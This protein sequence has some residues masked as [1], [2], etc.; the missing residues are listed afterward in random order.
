VSESVR[1]LLVEDSETDAKLIIHELDRALGRLHTQRVDT[2]AGLQQ[3]LE[4]ER[5]D[6]ILCDWSLPGLDALAAIELL[7]DKELDIP[8]I[9]VSGTVGEEA[10][11]RAMR[12]G[13]RDYVLKDKLARLPVAVEREIRET[14]ARLERRRSQEALRISE[15][16]FARLSESGI[17]GIAIADLIGGILEANDAYL[18]ICGFTREELLEGKMN[19]ARMTP[20]EFKPL[21][22]KAVELL[23]TTGAAAPWEMEHIRN[24]GTRIPVM[25]AVAMLDEARCLAIIT[26]LSERRRAEE[27]LRRTEEQ[28]RH[29]QKM[30]AIGILA[31]G[32]AH[33]FNNLLSVILGY[34]G[35]I[36][37]DLAP[38]HPLRAD[39]EEIKS[40]GER[41]ASLT[42]R[43][44]AF[45]RQQ[46]VEPRI[47]DVNEVINNIDA[48]LRRLIRE[49]VTLVT[50]LGAPLGSCRADPGQ[51]EQ[52]LMNLAVNAVDAMPGGG[53]LTLE[54]ANVDLDEEYVVAHIGMKPGRY[55]LLAVSDTG[56]G[57]TKATQAR[58]FEPFFTTKEKGKGTGLGLA[59]VFGI[60]Q[61]AGG[62]IQLY[63]EL[64]HG[65]TFKIYLPRVD[66]VPER[67]TASVAPPRARGAETILLVEDEDQL[68]RVAAGILRR[69]GFQVLEGS[70]GPEALGIIDKNPEPIDLL[71]TDV[72]M[73]HMNGRE[74]AERVRA[75]RPD[76]KILFTSG[77]TDGILEGE[78]PSG[79][80]F[81][82]KPFTPG[83]L[84]T[85]IR[86]ILDAAADPSR[87]LSKKGLPDR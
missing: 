25:V 45:S 27:Q 44:L 41:G 56:V 3:A 9:I 28:L 83:A 58:V 35:M 29:V 73:P 53:R 6:V 78:L 75:D 68:R 50:R 86:E 22:D 57:M 5:W 20:L 69:S 46:V 80:A 62:S 72:V 51:I 49:D 8:L 31:G 63:S 26:D 42:R 33:D 39:V 43:L 48:M 4:R 74:L 18:R 79:A 77:Y 84:T 19:W 37:E 66:L 52:I 1:V 24:D 36:L 23:R 67:G 76:I 71:M 38:D 30:E 21:T 7:K 13:A 65:T 85:K 64:G 12:A 70:N 59:T 60:V 81:L 16:R 2:A 14:R 61:Q 10:A 55:V 40:A 32:V 54:T 11:V 34:C 87:W 47:L 82:Q 15:A 17:V